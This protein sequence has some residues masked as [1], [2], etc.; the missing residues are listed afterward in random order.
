MRKIH[1]DMLQ[2]P[3]SYFMALANHCE[4][5]LVLTLS[6]SHHEL[7]ND[8]TI[9]WQVQVPAFRNW[10]EDKEQLISSVKL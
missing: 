4:N 3:G 7:L 10:P 2:I 9:L 6:H 5:G 8:A 1:P